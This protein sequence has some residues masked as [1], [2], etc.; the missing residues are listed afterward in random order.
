MAA[1][2]KHKRRENNKKNAA[3]VSESKL[4]ASGPGYDPVAALMNTIINFRPSKKKRIY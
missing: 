3:K 1:R 4:K 2:K